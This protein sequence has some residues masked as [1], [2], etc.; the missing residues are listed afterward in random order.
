MDF[1][2]Y[3]YDIKKNI[4]LLVSSFLLSYKCHTSDFNSYLIVS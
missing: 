1:S 4:A 2:N 3:K